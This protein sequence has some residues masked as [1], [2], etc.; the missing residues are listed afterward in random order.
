MQIIK[1]RPE[2]LKH[3]VACFEAL[4][5]TRPEYLNMRLDI[6]NMR[7]DAWNTNSNSHESWK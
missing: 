6:S 2:R 5:N 7:P 3:A 4:A 1:N